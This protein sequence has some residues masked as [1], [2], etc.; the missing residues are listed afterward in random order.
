M[1]IL[2]ADDHALFA[3]SMELFLQSSKNWSVVDA[4]RSG[5]ALL[6][7]PHLRS[8][9]L[10]LLDVK[11]PD[12][13]GLDCVAELK[14]SYPNLKYLVLTGQPTHAAVARAMTLGILGFIT[15]SC[16]VNELLKALQRVAN[17]GEYFDAPTRLLIKEVN[18]GALGEP[19][20]KRESEIL[21]EIARGLTSTELG[22]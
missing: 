4:V 2:L 11:M 6:D 19:L 9:N 20:S 22:R 7:S 14:A 18:A 3:E 1:K 21:H 16:G 5:R 13:N 10:V 17:G 15:K 8:A 12:I